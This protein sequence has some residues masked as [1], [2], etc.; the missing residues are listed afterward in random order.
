MHHWLCH[1]L[2]HGI[3][4]SAMH[5]SIQASARIAFMTT[6]ARLKLR[7]QRFSFKRG[8][9]RVF[10]ATAISDNY[11]QS[12][13]AQLADARAIASDFQI[14]GEDLRAALSQYGTRR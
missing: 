5:A 10:D 9:A 1:S 6:I 12:P 3:A 8:L 11:N 2:P 14:T 13:S 4:R 7:K